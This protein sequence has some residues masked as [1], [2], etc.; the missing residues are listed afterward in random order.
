SGDTG[1][2]MYALPGL[3]L[4]LVGTGRYREGAVVFEDAIAVGKKY[5]VTS[6]RARARAMAAGYHVDLFAFD[7]AE[8]LQLEARER[9]KSAG[10]VPPQVSASVDLL[11]TYARSHELG[12]AEELLPSVA[13]LVRSAGGWHGWLWRMRFTDVQAEIA[14]GRRDWDAVIEHAVSAI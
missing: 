10:F 8:A 2:I 6:L 12:R 9:A 7:N 11:F 5:G 14:A 3:A 13:E 4:S 1:Y